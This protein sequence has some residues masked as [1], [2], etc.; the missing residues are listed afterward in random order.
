MPARGRGSDAASGPQRDFLH[1]GPPKT[2]TTYVQ[3][4]LFGNRRELRQA[5]V[6]LP[7]RATAKHFGAVGDL[8]GRRRGKRR[9]SG[10]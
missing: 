1:I 7:G 3:S 10:A 2:G 5:G 8:R 4:I 6:L 9:N